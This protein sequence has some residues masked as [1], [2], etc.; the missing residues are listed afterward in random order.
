MAIGIGLGLA[1]FPFQQ[2]D[3][4]WRWVELCEEGGVD[5]IWQTDRLISSEPFLECI[6]A[7]AAIAGATQRIKFGMNVA[8]AALRDPLVLAKQCATIDFLSKGRMLPAFGIG[9]ARAPEWQATGRGTK[10]RGKRTDEALDIISQLWRGGPVSL[11]GEHYQYHDAVISPLPTQRELP[12]WIGG[13]SEAAIKRTARIGTGWQ[14]GLESPQQA[15]LAKKSIVEA[16]KVSGRHIDDDH[17]GT[18]FF[19]YFGKASNDIAQRELSRFS[20]LA[21]GK[22]LSHTVAIGTKQIHQRI[23]QYAEEGI[24]KFILRPMGN[25]DA[26]LLEQSRLLINEVLPEFKVP[27]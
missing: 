26:D 23:N 3:N 27:A 12:L 15:G 22:D 20:K 14:A 2:V 6:T 11:D 8:S 16:L 9:T 18:G 17:Y 24:S 21:P 13:S 1:R 5:S 4:F 19:F 25:D 10:G 7:L